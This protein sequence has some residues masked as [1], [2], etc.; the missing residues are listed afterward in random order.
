MK[1]NLRELL[2]DY[3]T[4]EGWGTSEADLQQTLMECET[5]FSET[6]CNHRWY[7]T[8][9]KVKELKGRFFLCTAYHTTGDN[10]WSDMGLELDKIDAILEVYPKKIETIIYVK[11]P[12][13]A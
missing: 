5:V 1:D 12:T 4:Q 9:K 2:T 11:E 13:N 6:V 10:H 3:C 8:L 7:D